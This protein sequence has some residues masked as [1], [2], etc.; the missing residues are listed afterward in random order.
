MKPKTK[1]ES[2][3]RPEVTPDFGKLPPLIQELAQ[4]IMERAAGDLIGDVEFTIAVIYDHEKY[5]QACPDRVMNQAMYDNKPVPK[6]ELH[7]HY[8]PEGKISDEYSFTLDFDVYGQIMQ[9]GLPRDS[10]CTKKG[11]RGKE[12]AIALAVEYATGKGYKTKI[13]NARIYFQLCRDNLLWMVLL[14][15]KR[16][17]V[18]GHYVK[19]CRAILIDVVN[20]LVVDDMEAKISNGR[21]SSSLFITER[22]VEP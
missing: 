2:P 6:Y 12:E 8:L 10:Y 19:H 15:Q 4:T 20:R 14:F 17:K 16:E 18:N 9:F 3:Y 21:N 22:V 5:F 7:Y 13:E 11:L 1:N